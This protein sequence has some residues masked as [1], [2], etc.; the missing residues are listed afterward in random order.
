[1]T[2]EVL[3][4]VRMWA[5]GRPVDLGPAKQRTVL[6]ALLVDAGEVVATSTLIRRVWGEDP[7]A[8]ARSGLYSYVTRLRR[9]L[10]KAAGA[11]PG[12]DPPVAL[13]HV[14]GGYRIDVDAAHLDLLRFRHLA[15]HARR[16][17]TDDERR[18]AA[19]DEAIRLWRGEALAD[20]TGE[21]AARTRDALTQQRLEVTVQWAR[22]HLRLGRASTVIGPLR[23]ASARHPLVEPLAALLI[24]ALCADDRS[25]EALDEY[26]KVRGRL[27]A[28]LGV[29]PGFELRRLHGSILHRV[30]AAPTP[31]QLP[32]DVHGFTGRRGHLAE[33]DAI[34]ATG[35]AQPTA[36]LVVALW[37]T[38]GVGKTA[39]AVH[40]AHR[41]AGR[42]ADGQ[43]YLNLRG[44]DP[45]GAP[46]TP[47]EAVRRL[48]D[49]FGVRPEDRPVD[50]DSQVDL[51]RSLVADKRVLVVL[52][53]AATVDQVRPLLPG[54]PGSVVVV[55][56]RNHLS[57]LV[58][59][60]GAH[61]LT[62][63]LLGAEEARQLL[64]ARVGA[65]LIAAEPSAV[66]EIVDRCAGLP[67]ALAVV[68]ARAAAQPASDLTGLAAQLR[69][70]GLGAFGDADPV[71]DVRAV[72]SW[73]YR[74][75]SAPAADLFRLL[76]L[77]PGP[78][79]GV[80]AAASLAGVPAAAA[81]AA[82]GEL[83]RANLVDE[84][85]PGR[86][87]SHDLLRAYAAELARQHDTADERRAALCRVLDHYLNTGCAAARAVNPHRDPITVAPVRPGVVVAPITGKEQALAWF[88]AEHAV[89][90]AAVSAAADADCDVYAWQ[91]AWT[92]ASFLDYRTY[93]QE[94]A[95]THRVGL[96]AAVRLA[97]VPGQ[98]YT[99]RILGRAWTRLGR[100]DAAEEH[101]RRALTLCGQLADHVGRAH[102]HLNLAWLSEQRRNHPDALRH[103]RDALDLYRTADHRAG[104]ASA[105]NQIGWYHAQLGDHA[106]AIIHCDEALRLQRATGN[107]YGQASTWHS[108][109]YAHHQLGDHERAA[110]S[111][112]HA[113]DLHRE[114]GD[115]YREAE[116]LARL[117]DTCRAAGD[118]AGARDAS[119]RAAAIR[120]QISA[121]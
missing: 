31:A 101:Y 3:G 90:V 70:D 71:A 82:L 66:D 113:I 102:T 119:R 96:A 14:P 62:L 63:G 100:H 18:C 110:A 107:R 104:Q 109:G 117:A 108:L 61:P 56:G 116:T 4:P 35:G 99:H 120:D 25:A 46:M 47:A 85:G 1:M 73:S 97:D 12:A 68:A 7:P 50:P 98:A 17:E 111:Y 81:R 24:E 65:A 22:S 6:A 106:S 27:A 19:L 42:F 76:A 53:N 45:S 37:G 83:V 9:V 57:G 28:E 49:A 84:P 60:E 21:W 91:L 54:S 30:P 79:V 51:Y 48:L 29:E 34:L 13:E 36:V 43:L 80:G 78:D 2:F 58:T 39:L 114:N 20:A 8:G 15:D 77:H 16:P 103:A 11:D 26:A 93:W 38:A 74:T 40:W 55:T 86:Y 75:L 112:R 44:F 59:V 69:G 115:R 94:L 89:L 52:D 33:L 23:E 92:L 72:F 64:G 95:D 105:L 88:T 5:A 87:A 32:L 121:C 10:R 118:P 67:L 41:I